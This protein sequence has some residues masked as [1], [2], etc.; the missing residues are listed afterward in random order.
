MSKTQPIQEVDVD[1]S[2]KPITTLPLP[3]SGVNSGAS[4]LG[5]AN[6][7]SAPSSPEVGRVSK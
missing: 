3:T 7:G 6:V 1:F 4:G 5:P 2:I